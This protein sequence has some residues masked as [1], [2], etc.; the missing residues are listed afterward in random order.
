MPLPPTLTVPY[1]QIQE[2]NVLS[3]LPQGSMVPTT[4]KLILHLQQGLTLSKSL[5]E[6]GWSLTQA[7]LQEASADSQ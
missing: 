4:G 7:T 2:W 5:S 6:E 1:P 3:T